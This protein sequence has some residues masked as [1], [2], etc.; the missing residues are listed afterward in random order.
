[1]KELMGNLLVKQ[2]IAMQQILG[3]LENDKNSTINKALTMLENN[4]KN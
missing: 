2:F 4:G 3:R 1:M